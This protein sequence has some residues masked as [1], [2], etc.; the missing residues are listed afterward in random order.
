MLDPQSLAPLADGAV[1]ALHVQCPWLFKG[2]WTAEGVGYSAKHNERFRTGDLVTWLGGENIA[3]NGRETSSHIKVRG[4][5]AEGLFTHRGPSSAHT[6]PHLPA[7]SHGA[8]SSAHTPPHSRTTRA[9]L[10]SLPPCLP[11]CACLPVWI[12]TDVRQPLTPPGARLQSL[13]RAHR[14]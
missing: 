11:V 1:G 6:P 5:L 7:G 14:G 4:R 3:F 9:A 13:P 2:Y 12:R 8:P 10:C